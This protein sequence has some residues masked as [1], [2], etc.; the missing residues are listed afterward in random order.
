MRVEVPFVPWQYPVVS[1]PCVDQTPP[2]RVTVPSFT[3]L[4]VR[5]WYS[6]RHYVVPL[7]YMSALTS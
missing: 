4:S 3:Q 6:L 1:A 2:H 7:I 5:V